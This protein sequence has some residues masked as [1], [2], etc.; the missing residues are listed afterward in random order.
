MLLARD[1]L[2]EANEFSLNQ[3]SH[4]LPPQS[5]SYLRILMVEMVDLHIRKAAGYS[6]L[7]TNDTWTNFRRAERLGIPAWQGVLVRK[8]DKTSRVENMVRDRR[9]N[10][11]GPSEGLRQ[12]LI[13]D[14]SY[15][16]IC[17]S[18]LDESTPGVRT[19]SP[20]KNPGA[21]DV[22]CVCFFNYAE[23]K[24]SGNKY[25]VWCYDMHLRAHNPPPETLVK[26]N[27]SRE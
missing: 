16:L 1:Q 21:H 4:L 15:D 10:Q 24:R 14:A 25:H 20:V 19:V 8:L 11:L 27:R 5:L 12:E 22:C 23:V 18:I 6:G 9:N 3:V 7:D 17:I 2:L 26:K 13:D